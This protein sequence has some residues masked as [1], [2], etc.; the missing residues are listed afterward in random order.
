MLENVTTI[1]LMVVHGWENV[2]G[3]KYC[4]ADVLSPPASLAKAL[5]YK[6]EPEARTAGSVA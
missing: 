5:K 3:G 2:R 1:A 6:P 4:K